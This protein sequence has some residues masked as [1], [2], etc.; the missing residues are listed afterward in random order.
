[1]CIYFLNFFFFK[2]S[3]F[4]PK[5]PGGSIGAPVIK[6]HNKVAQ[7]FTLC[8]LECLLSILFAYQLYGGGEGGGGN[9]W[10]RSN[11]YRA[12]KTNINTLRGGLLKI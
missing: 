2:L 5:D 7:V 12:I 9:F 6:Y 10:D 1:M 11:H 8:R 3:T 4:L